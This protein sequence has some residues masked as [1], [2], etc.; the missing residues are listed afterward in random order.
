MY[1]NVAFL[2]IS[3]LYIIGAMKKI[4]MLTNKS[5]QPSNINPNILHMSKS[6]RPFLVFP[7]ATAAAMSPAPAAA[8]TPPPTQEEKMTW[9]EPTWLLL[10][11]MAEQ[12]TPDQFLA[13]RTDILNV[14]YTICRNLP[15]HFCAEHAKDHLNKIQFLTGAVRTRDDLIRVLY[16]FHNYVNARKHYEL[17][18]V[19]NLEKYARTNI[20]NVVYNF[21]IHYQEK[22]KNPKMISNELY[23]SR[24]IIQLREWFS[25]NIQLFIS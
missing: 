22:S 20:K 13:H 2:Y 17:F 3:S 21:F 24:I 5:I 1:N 7:G 15:C 4:S 23:R 16:E 18:P 6:P 9:G 14:I 10:H 19:E 25:N 8:A 12:I 11:S